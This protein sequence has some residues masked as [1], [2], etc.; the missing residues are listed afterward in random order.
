MIYNNLNSLELIKIAVEEEGCSLSNNGA[1]L[2]YTGEHTGRS[3]NAKYY[4]FESS[5]KNIL[6]WKR[7][8]KITKSKYKKIKGKFT[9]YADNNKLY[10][11]DTLLVRDPSHSI[12]FRVYTE[13]ARHSLFVRNMFITEDQA[14]DLPESPVVFQIMHFPSLLKEPTVIISIE[15]GLILISGTFY[16]GEIKKAAFSVISLLSPLTTSSLPMHCS[17]NID[18]N[19]EN[20]AIFFGLSG[21]G[22]TTL[23]SHPNRILIGDDEHLWTDTGLTNIEGGC[24]AKTLNLSKNTEPEI[25]KSCMKTGTMFENVT[26]VSGIPDFTDSSITENGRA[27]YSLDVVDNAHV[28]GYVNKHPKNIIMLTCDAFGVLPPVCK[29]TPQEAYDQFLLGYTAKVA[30]TEQ[31]VK[32]PKPTF[33]PCF[34]DPFMPLKK[35]QYA[36]LLKDKIEK[37]DVNCWLVNTGWTKG[38]YGRGERISLNTTRHIIDLILDGM[39]T[40]VPYMKH[41]YTGFSIPLLNYADNEIMFPEQGWKNIEEYKKAA[42]KLLNLMRLK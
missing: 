33:S 7:N 2:T 16:S 8:N 24:Y 30:G 23:S 41:K 9:Q 3:P 36:N 20:P 22:K 25:W 19:N 15:D 39:L 11:Q 13:F 21:T 6:D 42:T 4:V 31:G 34:G 27:S 37:H 38:P 29:L 18:K 26:A 32:E 17:V 1:L 12:G 40:K 28:L 5:M 35:K 14:V 10:L